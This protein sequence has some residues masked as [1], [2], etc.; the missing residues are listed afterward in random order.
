MLLTFSAGMLEGH[1]R[2]E[3]PAVHRE[4]GPGGRQRGSLCG[5]PGWAW[6]E[7]AP[8]G[9]AVHAVL[10]GGRV[11]AGWEEAAHCGEA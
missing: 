1:R 6:G 2:C 7:V 5:R 3:L 11:G 10:A 8:G 9:R 4:A